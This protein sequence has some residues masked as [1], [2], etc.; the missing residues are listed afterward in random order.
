[1]YVYVSLCFD[2]E[3]SVII[4][5]VSV[6]VYCEVR[7]LL[8]TLEVKSGLQSYC[9]ATTCMCL[10]QSL[11][12]SVQRGHGSLLNL[13]NGESRLGVLLIEFGVL[14]SISN[15]NQKFGFM[16]SISYFKVIVQQ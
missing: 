1:M 9:Q 16:E 5:S 7:F 3:E 10:T 4:H 6:C 2:S 13:I 15:K 11:S 14:G 12:S 8:D